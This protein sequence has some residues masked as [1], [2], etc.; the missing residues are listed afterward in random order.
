M[1]G[2]VVFFFMDSSTCAYLD[3]RFIVRRGMFVVNGCYMCRKDWDLV[4]HLPPHCAFISLIP[5]GG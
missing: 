5:Y 2:R 1:P 4:N 3:S